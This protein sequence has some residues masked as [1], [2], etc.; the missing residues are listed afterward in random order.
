ML[1]VALS[2][3]LFL[4]NLNLSNHFTEKF[5]SGTLQNEMTVLLFT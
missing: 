3:G 4:Q 1:A 5:D 2:H